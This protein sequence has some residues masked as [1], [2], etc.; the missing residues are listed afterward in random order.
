MILKP[1]SQL[2]YRCDSEAWFT[3]RY[4]CDSEAWFT[5]RYRCDSEAWFTVRYSVILKPGSQ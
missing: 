2:R 4:R 1:G 5:V 3:V